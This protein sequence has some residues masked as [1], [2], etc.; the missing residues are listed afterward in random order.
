MRT[1][2]AARNASAGSATGAS[3]SASAGVDSSGSRGEVEVVHAVDFKN[4]VMGDR[5][6]SD[7]GEIAQAP[8]VVEA[9]V[10]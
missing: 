8:S 4:A 6:A 7:A 10:A 9:A 1:R 5:L 2:P 3:A